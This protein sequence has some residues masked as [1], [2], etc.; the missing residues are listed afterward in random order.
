MR[1]IAQM[2]GQRDILIRISIGDFGFPDR[3]ICNYYSK[4]PERMKLWS[5]KQQ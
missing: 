4:I 2:A 3:N 5:N 1:M